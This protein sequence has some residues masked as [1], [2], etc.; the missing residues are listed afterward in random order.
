MCMA[1]HGISLGWWLLSCMGSPALALYPMLVWERPVAFSLHCSALAGRHQSTPEASQRV[2]N[3]V[4]SRE[5]W[6]KSRGIV[7]RRGRSLSLPPAAEVFSL[8]TVSS[9]SSPEA[10]FPSWGGMI[11]A[12][13]KYLDI[14]LGILTR[15]S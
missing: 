8:F 9:G 3:G 2:S 15:P 7:E 6:G 4:G 12:A 5:A 11:P 10:L 1:S 13:K 14:F